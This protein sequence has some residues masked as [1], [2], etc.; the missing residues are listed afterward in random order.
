MRHLCDSNVL[1]GIVV[2]RHPHHISALRWLD[3]FGAAD[4]VIVCR[5]TQISFL[6]LLTTRAVMREVVQTN[7][8]AIALLSDLLSHPAF[9]FVDSE[10]ANI[11]N[12]W[13]AAADARTVSPKIWM[14]TYLAAFA[15][16]HSFRFVTFDS[17]FE[18]LRRMGLDLLV[19]S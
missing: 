18:K 3:G 6:R 7:S 14:D 19:L 5:Q 13:L 11:E 1:L 10:P 17:A 9:E 2:E 8:A 16:G 12:L 4:K 15:R